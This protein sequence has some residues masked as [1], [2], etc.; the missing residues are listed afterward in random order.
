MA[1]RPHGGAA[2]RVKKS[3]Q[4]AEKALCKGLNPA[5]PKRSPLLDN[6]WENQ[7]VLSYS[8]NPRSP[9]RCNA[10]FL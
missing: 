6:I 9:W 5:R 3:I 7:Y 4:G 8:T 1:K 2:G 10:A